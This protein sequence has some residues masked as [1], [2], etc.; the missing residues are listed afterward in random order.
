MSMEAGFFGLG[1]IC[2]CSVASDCDDPNTRINLGVQLLCHVVA[3]HVRQSNVHE[4]CIYLAKRYLLNATATS[5]SLE[6]LMTLQP[7]RGNEH[8]SRVIVVLDDQDVE[9]PAGLCRGPPG[10]FLPPDFGSLL[11]RPAI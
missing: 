6:D 9:W 8:F 4:Y 3:Q 2:G 1:P 7:Q 5:N 10:R 11:P